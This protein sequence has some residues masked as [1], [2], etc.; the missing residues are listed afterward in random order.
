MPVYGKSRKRQL[1]K[2]TLNLLSPTKHSK[3]RSSEEVDEPCSQS[4]N[5]F[6]SF[7]SD[8]SSID[9]IDAI[10]N[11]AIEK[12]PIFTK[13]IQR[14]SKIPQEKSH[15]KLNSVFSCFE[16]LENA[17]YQPVKT[18]KL[19]DSYSA[20]KTTMFRVDAELK[21]VDKQVSENVNTLHQRISELEANA[22]HNGENFDAV[23]KTLKLPIALPSELNVKMKH[24]GG[25]LRSFKA[26]NG[27]LSEEEDDDN[28]LLED[29]HLK[30]KASRNSVQCK[31]FDDLKVKNHDETN[32][33]EFEMIVEQI[34]R[35]L[36]LE[37]NKYELLEVTVDLLLRIRNNQSFGLYLKKSCQHKDNIGYK[38]VKSLLMRSMDYSLFTLLLILHFE[39]N[40]IN[41][42][43][44]M[45]KLL[46]DPDILVTQYVESMGIPKS[47]KLLYCLLSDW[48]SDYPSQP[49]CGV[50][51]TR[52]GKSSPCYF[53]KLN[54]N[55]K[56][57]IMELVTHCLLNSSDEILF[58]TFDYLKAIAPLINSSDIKETIPL[59]GKH[60][61]GFG[62]LDTRT[63]NSLL[64][65]AIII[66]CTH[67]DP[68]I[69][70]QLLSVKNWCKIWSVIDDANIFSNEKLTPERE[71]QAL[72]AI[73]FAF[74]FLDS[75][76][77]KENDLEL[78]HKTLKLCSNHCR[79]STL[80]YHCIG[81][82]ICIAFRFFKKFKLLNDANYSLIESTCAIFQK[83][84]VKFENKVGAE[85]QDIMNQFNLR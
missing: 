48:S 85:I 69:T 82:I 74:N 37:N 29:E 60:I 22:L 70:D 47:K 45:R 4:S 18:M 44:L 26:T 84:E 13:C 39:I 23:P 59:L 36:S 42:D 75:R 83:S 58:E 9:P 66:V 41:V 32:K 64:E 21:L 53:S 52:I 50:L 7:T 77:I 63:Y 20:R 27:P 78:L 38:A 28:S 54:S 11:I 16:D 67:E 34:D 25:T 3:N 1:F 62:T 43:L 30:E 19:D 35:S 6:S 80:Q 2:S 76:D 14:K 79:Y 24:Y 15:L 17:D 10:A 8:D 49:I 72:L 55:S 65:V 31:S 73:G 57:S 68:L 40:E 12:E 46:Q 56:V 33:L 51:L 81:Y 61:R 71:K 5:L